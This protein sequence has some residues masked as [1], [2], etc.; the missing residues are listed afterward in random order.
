MGDHGYHLGEHGWWNKVTV[1]ELSARPPLIVWAPGAPGMGKRAPG[2][3][4]F[5]DVYPTIAALCGLQPPAGL[6]GTS[7][8]PLLDDPSRAGKRA[9]YTQ[10]VRGG[11]MGRS[12]RTDRW[13]YTEWLDGKQGV[14]LYDHTVDPL[15]YHNL[16]RDPGHAATLT[17]M[18]AVLHAQRP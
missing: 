6:E 2:L 8:R 13:R 18:R 7:F 15:E 3:V 17:E 9:A 11:G 5:I 12:V 10:V 16:A 4:E 14:E 1:F